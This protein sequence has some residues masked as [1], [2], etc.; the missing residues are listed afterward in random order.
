MKNKRPGILFQTPG[1]LFIINKDVEKMHRPK[2]GFCAAML[3][4]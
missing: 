2:A 4:K 3:K 1:L